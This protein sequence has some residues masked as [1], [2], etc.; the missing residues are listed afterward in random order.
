MGN[1]IWTVTGHAMC[2]CFHYFLLKSRVEAFPSSFR[3]SDE[4]LSS[5]SFDGTDSWVVGWLSDASALLQVFWWLLQ[6]LI[7]G[8]YVR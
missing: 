1:G 7:V 4:K 6:K 5:W 3:G 8:L 2:L